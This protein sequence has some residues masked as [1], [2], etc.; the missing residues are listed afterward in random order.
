MG[1]LDNLGNLPLILQNI[2]N[3]N[4]FKIYKKTRIQSLIKYN[5]FVIDY[6]AVF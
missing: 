6:K 4:Y 2:Y 3:R 1:N 5:T